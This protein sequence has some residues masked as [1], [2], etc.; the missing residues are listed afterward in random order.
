MVV[1]IV[2]RIEDNKNCISNYLSIQQ[3]KMLYKM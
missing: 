1:Q 3:K 2:S